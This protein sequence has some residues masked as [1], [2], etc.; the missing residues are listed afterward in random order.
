M[1][2]DRARSHPVNGHI[3]TRPVPGEVLADDGRI[4]NGYGDLLRLFKLYALD[5]D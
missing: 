4:A 1:A 3:R 5:E 2:T